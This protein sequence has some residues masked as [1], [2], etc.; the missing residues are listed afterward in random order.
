[1]PDARADTETLLNSAHGLR[2]SEVIKRFTGWRYSDYQAAKK[3][4]LALRLGKRLN[5]ASKA[6]HQGMLRLKKPLGI[7]GV[8]LHRAVDDYR[9]IFTELERD[10]PKVGSTFRDP[11][12]MSTSIDPK[13]ASDH[14]A[15]I[16][17]FKLGDYPAR[18]VI[19]SR[20]DRE[21][22]WVGPIAKAKFRQQREV[23]LAPDSRLRVLAGRFDDAGRPVIL[24]EQL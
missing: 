23:V 16:L 19:L 22:V 2:G 6:L 5:L 3:M 15:D 14:L 1:M 4:N 8:E 11:G 20:G 10:L 9:A 18:L 12:W 24:C 17:K 13:A 21:V 7:E